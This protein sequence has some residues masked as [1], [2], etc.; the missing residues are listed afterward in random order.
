MIGIVL[1]GGLASRLGGG[2]KGL[3]Q[4]GGRAILDR[5]IAAVRPQCEA[6]VVSANGD[7]ARFA[8]LGCPVVADDLSGHLGPLA[9][10]LAGL[11]WVA[12][13]RSRQDVAL[14]VPADTP[15]LPP[16][17]ATRLAAARA[18]HGASIVCARSAGSTHFVAALWS[19]ALRHDLRVALEQG[20]VR[21]VRRFLAGHACAYVDWPS[22]PYDP[23]FNVNEPNDIVE[24]ERIARL[25]D[26]LSA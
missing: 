21:Q 7:P 1:A 26:A 22:E 9:G 10:V 14:T 11:D 16:D 19:V 6:L 17:L 13:H 12:E 20:Q 23:F 18:L 2:D 4:I 3:R 5:V 24:A 25:H 8:A 15:F